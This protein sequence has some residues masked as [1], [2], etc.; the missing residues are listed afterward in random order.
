[1]KQLSIICGVFLLMAFSCEEPTSSRPSSGIYEGTF[2]YIA[3]NGQQYNN[4]VEVR[5]SEY[6]T[7][8]S[9]AGSNRVPAGG[10]GRYQYLEGNYILFRDEN[11]W[12]ADFDWGL[13]LSG[14]YRYTFDGEN[15]TLVKSGQSGNTNYRYELRKR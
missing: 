3:S 5:L 10:N 7:Y 14:E 11:I 1:M 15:L 8:S 13:I 9:S 12:T 4:A 6:S 2:Y